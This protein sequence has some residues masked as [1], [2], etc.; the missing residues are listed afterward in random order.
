MENEKDFDYE[1]IGRVNHSQETKSFFLYHVT[2]MPLDF[3]VFLKWKDPL[4][5]AG[6]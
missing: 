3:P 4:T 1:I 2:L 6:I 5:Q